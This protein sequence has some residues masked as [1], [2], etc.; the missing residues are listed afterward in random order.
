MQRTSTLSPQLRPC[1]VMSGLLFL[2]WRFDPSLRHAAA[3]LPPLSG[4]QKVPLSFLK[5]DSLPPFSTH[6]SRSLFPRFCCGQP[7]IV[8]TV[9]AFS[10]FSKPADGVVAGPSG[11]KIPSEGNRGRKKH[12]GLRIPL[13]FRVSSCTILILWVQGSRVS[14]C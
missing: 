9:L 2:A 8:K 10:P 13:Q 3:Y 4:P 1:P 14:F 11:G 6:L 7:M 5:D 12:P